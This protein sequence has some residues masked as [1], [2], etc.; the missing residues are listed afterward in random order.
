LLG[1]AYDSLMLPDKAYQ[2]YSDAIERAPGEDDNYLALA[3]FAIEHAN[4]K[5]ARQVLARGLQKVPNSAKLKLENGLS[6]AIEGNFEAAKESFAE[7]NSAD[8]RWS[9]PLLA[10]GVTHLQTGHPDDAANCFRHAKQLAPGDYRCYYLQAVALTRSHSGQ[11]PATRAMIIRELQRAIALAPERAEPRVAL[12][13]AEIA[14]GKPALAES[15]LRE[16]IR[17]APSQPDALYNMA[18]LCRREGKHEEAARLL[19][20]FQRLKDK[21][22]D[23]ENQFVLILKTVDKA[24]R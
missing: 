9:M 22:H 20:T 7:A 24:D 1:D 12:A 16:A 19:N 2:A 21:S 4:R 10:L 6:W 15:Q 18:L 11:E 14:D 17:I 8:S 13:K 3:A 5:F 23:E